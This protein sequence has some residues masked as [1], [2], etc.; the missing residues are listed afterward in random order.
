MFALALSACGRIGF[1]DGSGSGSGTGPDG[2][3]VGP[4]SGWAQLSPSASWS[5][6]VAVDHSLWCWGLDSIDFAGD[7]QIVAPM[8]VGSAS[9]QSIATWSTP[10]GTD[11]LCGV[12]TDGS[13][14]CWGDDAVGEV[15]N[16]TTDSGEPAPV[17]VAGTW[18]AV[19]VG[20]QFTCGIQT[21][22]SLWCW[23][24]NGYGQLG[25]G[26]TNDQY[27]PQQVPGSWSA[28]STGSDYACGIQTDGSL[29]CWGDNYN[30]VIGDGTANNESSPTRAPGS[31]TAVSARS[32]AHVCALADDGTAWCWGCNGEGALGTGDGVNYEAPHSIGMKL[33]S[34]S[35]GDDHSCGVDASNALWCWGNDSHGQLGMDEPTTG[36]VLSPMRVT[37]A[38]TVGA[39]GTGG[40]ETCVV[41]AQ[42]VASCVGRGSYGQ[43]GGSAGEVHAPVLA[44]G[45]TDW[46]QI[47]AGGTHVCA[48]T[49]D[50]A[51]HCW[52]L[53]SEGEVGDG[54]ELDRQAPVTAGTGFVRI[55]AGP[56]TSLGVVAGGAGA[57]LWGCDWYGGSN[58]P[59]AEQL[60]MAGWM[61][62]AAGDE[63]SCGI[64]GSQLFCRGDNSYG[65]LGDGTNNSEDNTMVTSPDGGW[66]AVA[67]GHSTTCGLD[68]SR[69]LLCWGQGDS[70][71]LGDGAGSDANTPQLVSV[72]T[73]LAPDGGSSGSRFS[74][75]DGFACAIVDDG[76][77]T[78][79]SLWCWG[80]N[81][82][83][84]L[85]DGTGSD[86][87]SAVQAGSRT[88]WW[89]VSAGSNH[90]C[91]IPADG[92]LWCWGDDTN[93][94]TSDPALGDDLA[95]YQVGT[96]TNWAH[97]AAADSF[98]CAVKTDG[99]RWCFGQDW[100]G[101]LGNNRAW[102]SSWVALP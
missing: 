45:R 66:L 50:G 94:E 30:G 98:T 32:D 97:V 16:G 33:A 79:G 6:G 15:G 26:N 82:Y 85:G 76:S 60:A 72:G 88:D 57:W 23:G 71:Q 78:K 52:G 80:S 62:E 92:T 1:G 91:A 9:W 18:T 101:E 11:Q 37:S 4:T 86:N 51:T 55:A 40:D 10:S 34:V 28:I 63:H 77:G 67:V 90:V 56:V 93:G 21:G 89:E 36:Y 54:S 64:N 61:Q 99:T 58:D 95:P 14:W 102:T 25:I 96:D 59:N 22:G 48:M 84:Q 81:W 87:D 68:A 43:N 12:Q 70:G 17:Q 100:D 38:P 8:Q 39:L 42:H 73:V 35:V 24:E 46:T 19:A 41:D 44:D 2:G 7:S 29:W 5:C 47:V 65:Q 3:V 31:W 83:G 27:S 69:E 74:I 75:G 53:N 20:G 13:L 49:S